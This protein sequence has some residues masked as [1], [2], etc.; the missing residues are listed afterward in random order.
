L[1][2]LATTTNH[3]IG[4]RSGRAAAATGERPRGSPLRLPTPRRAS[5]PQPSVRRP[6]SGCAPRTSR[7]IRG[8]VYGQVAGARRRSRRSRSSP[9]TARIVFPA[10]RKRQRRPTRRALPFGAHTCRP[11]GAWRMRLPGGLAG[12]ARDLKNGR[13]EVSRGWVRTGR[14]VTTGRTHPR[15]ALVKVSGGG[16]AHG[17]DRWRGDR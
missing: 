12:H 9:R 10:P 8:G 6:A 2:W 5:E 13:E 16:A 7:R 15:R 4:D 14:D 1:G 11:A 3:P 17:G